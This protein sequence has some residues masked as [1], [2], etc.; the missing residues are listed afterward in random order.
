MSVLYIRAL[1]L[2][3]VESALLSFHFGNFCFHSVCLGKRSLLFP[4]QVGNSFFF[5][6]STMLQYSV[7]FWVLSVYYLFVLSPISV[8][9]EGG[10]LLYSFSWKDYFPFDSSL[11]RKW[12]WLHFLCNTILHPVQQCMG[13]IISYSMAWEFYDIGFVIF[14]EFL[15]ADKHRRKPFT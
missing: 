13:L 14:K 15:K 6:F 3:C 11:G 2:F 12:T 7:L 9:G 5:S 1:I 4:D 8:T 10:I